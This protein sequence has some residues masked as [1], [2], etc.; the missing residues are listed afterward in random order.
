MRASVCLRQ[1]SLRK[2]C[3]GTRSALALHITAKTAFDVLHAGLPR[4]Q[5]SENLQSIASAMRPVG[6]RGNYYYF[7]LHS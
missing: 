2:L 4:V 7:V 6:V 3:D 1:I 5:E